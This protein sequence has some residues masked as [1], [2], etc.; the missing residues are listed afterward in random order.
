MHIRS[1]VSSMSL[2]GTGAEIYFA[3]RRSRNWSKHHLF[4]DS[5]LEPC[6]VQFSSGWSS[7]TSSHTAQKPVGPAN[8]ERRPSRGWS[9]ADRH[10]TKVRICASTLCHRLPTTASHLR[11]PIPFI[12]SLSLLTDF[13]ATLHPVF[14]GSITP[15]FAAVLATRSCV[16]CGPTGPASQ[17]L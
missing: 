13:A 9:F 17:M 10:L 3:A 6:S 15:A 14:S 8:L 16:S 11:R 12:L 5:Q 1:Y 2:V 7:R 4:I